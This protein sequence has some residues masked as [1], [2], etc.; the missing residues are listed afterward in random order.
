VEINFRCPGLAIRENES[1]AF[2]T[3]SNGKI[4][5]NILQYDQYEDNITYT[6]S[7]SKLFINRKE[8][9]YGAIVKCV[10]MAADRKE[11]KDGYDYVLIMQYR[12]QIIIK[13]YVT[14]F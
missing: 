13:S 10:F 9:N 2:L 14:K 6:L 5:L 7:K 11:A 4:Y 3:Q 12:T 8:L 1:L